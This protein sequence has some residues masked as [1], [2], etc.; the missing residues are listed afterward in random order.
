MAPICNIPKFCGFQLHIPDTPRFST[1]INKLVDEVNY[2]KYFGYKQGSCGMKRTVPDFN[3]PGQTLDNREGGGARQGAPNS[4]WAHTLVN[5]TDAHPII[6][7]G[8]K[9][10]STKTGSVVSNSNCLALTP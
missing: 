10:D 1:M 4:H 2:L 9:Q 7:N 8:H 3:T 5:T 6:S